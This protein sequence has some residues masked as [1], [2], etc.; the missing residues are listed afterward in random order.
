M[1]KLRLRKKLRNLLP[2]FPQFGSGNGCDV[3]GSI[4]R[5]FYLG[6]EHVYVWPVADL[7]Q[8]PGGVKPFDKTLKEDSSIEGP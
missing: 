3:G 5:Q 6:K 2:K 8:K 1:K 7:G 4:D